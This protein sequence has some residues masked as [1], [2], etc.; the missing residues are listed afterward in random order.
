[1]VMDRMSWMFRSMSLRIVRSGGGT[2]EL[3][4]RHNRWLEIRGRSRGWFPGRWDNGL[5]TENFMI[6]VGQL[7]NEF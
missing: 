1:M 3:R 7:E 2:W 5:T 4:Q 6:S